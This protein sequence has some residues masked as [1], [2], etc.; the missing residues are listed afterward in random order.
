[1][2][3]H[4]VDVMVT[5]GTG[6][7][8][9][10]L[11]AELTRTRGVVA[12]VRRANERAAEL[13]RFVDEHGGDASRLVVVEGDVEVPGLAVEGR[14]DAVRDVFHLAARFAFRLGAEEARRAN[15]DGS[16]HVAEWARA[17]PALRRF[18]YLGGYRMMARS[19]IVRG[20]AHGVDASLARLSDD[21]RKRLYRDHG[22]YEA[23]KHESYLAVRA[24]AHAHELPW[25][26]VH[27]SSVIGDARTGETTQTTGFGDL[28]ARLFCGQLPAL[29]GSARTFLPL[30]TVDY[31][32]RFL[33]T[34]PER[35]ETEGEDLCVLDPETPDL[36]VLVR[37]IADHLGVAA[38]RM[39][40][41]VGLVR[42][43]PAKL[44]G[45]E[46]ESLRFL[47][48]ER[49]DIASA[50]AHAGAVGLARPPIERAVRRWSDFLVSTRFGDDPR[51]DRGSLRDGAFVVG[52]PQTAE[53][54]FLHGLPFNSDAWKPVADALGVPHARIDLPGLGRS[55]P[56]DLDAV[57]WLDRLLAGRD[58]PVYLVGHSLGAALA[59]RYAHAHPD[60]VAGL[61][62]VSPAFLQRRASRLL[63]IPP[64]VSLSL[65][66][67]TAAALAERLLPE[68]AG[69]RADS[70]EASRILESA[71]SD[72][73]RRG[74]AARVAKALA[75]ASKEPV[76][77]T[78]RCDLE[79]IKA[80]VVL[81]HG[82]HDPLLFS[83]RHPVQAVPGTAHN[84]HISSP[85]AVVAHLRRL[86]SV[87]SSVVALR[88]PSV[89][90][91]N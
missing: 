82:E 52:D 58:E 81:V 35:A 77:A 21:E 42:A 27:P 40:L 65:R 29:V 76:R 15:V 70:P 31:L 13:R 16:L 9:R 22:G 25:T 54:V 56:T 90:L 57:A 74:V 8:G 69:A 62:L 80:P 5:G 86:L 48:E 7:I 78:L 28:V 51:A 72:L 12:P 14:F 38:P 83:S 89:P 55:A 45:I 11:L 19:S 63:R 75:R 87:R 24:F 33:A 88:P 60:Q 17:R 41:P 44:T 4:D 3:E 68:L 49:Y 10:W 84:P 2:N 67:S 6:L 32:A 47:S 36:P 39:I 66:R 43:L 37:Q 73:R 18:V 59:V 1:M 26:A 64:A 20:P 23:S 79:S 34:V 85:Q 61:A 71:T 91:H 53:V 30:V 46:P 50:E